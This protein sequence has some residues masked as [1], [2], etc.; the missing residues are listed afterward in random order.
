MDS[1]GRAAGERFCPVIL[2]V[3]VCVRVCVAAACKRLLQTCSWGN[4]RSTCEK[5]NC[6]IM[7]LSWTSCSLFSVIGVWRER[8]ESD[9]K[10]FFLL[11]M[12][13][14]WFAQFVVWLFLLLIYFT[15]WPVIGLR[16]RFSA[17]WKQPGGAAGVQFSLRLGLN[18]IM[19][20]GYYG[21]FDQRG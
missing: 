3:I 10:N 19:Q 13:D 9:Q 14:V 17:A 5:E 4:D 16:L 1:A 12:S 7:W 18:Y 8:R 15:F 2:V 11:N 6:R 20:R 21:I